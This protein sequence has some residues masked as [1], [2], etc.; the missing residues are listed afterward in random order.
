M[1]A[2]GLMGELSWL[3]RRAVPEQSTRTEVARLRPL[4]E[5]VETG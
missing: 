3:F 1:P 4:V 5:L 2:Y